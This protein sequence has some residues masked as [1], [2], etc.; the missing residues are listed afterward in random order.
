[1]RIRDAQPADAAAIAALLGELGYPA[2]PLRVERRL[3]RISNDADSRLFVAELDG[4]V[5][6]LAGLHLLPL[7]QRDEVGAELTAM[8]V[9]A[10]YRRKGVGAELVRAVEHEA[11][12]RGCGRLA[13]G[14]ANRR[15]DAHAFYERLGFESTG[16]RF[17]KT[18]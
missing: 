17:A 14:S 4:E 13:L 7:V 11:R 15:S 6:G 2:D 5:A 16:R 12:L 3:R 8:V 10:A 18:L 1:L 9:G